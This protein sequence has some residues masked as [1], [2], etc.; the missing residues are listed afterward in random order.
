[1]RDEIKP[2]PKKITSAQQKIPPEV[3]SILTEEERKNREDAFQAD[4]DK[5]KQ[6]EL[7]R[8]EAESKEYFAKESQARI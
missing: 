1:M 4:E 5:K 8:L 7:D 6:E 2:D 3:W